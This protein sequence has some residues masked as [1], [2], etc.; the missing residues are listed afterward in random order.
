[1]R[2]LY[3]GKELALLKRWTGSG[4][5]CSDAHRLR[6]QEEY[7]QLALN[8]LLQAKPPRPEGP[9]P[10]EAKSGKPSAV[11]EPAD[12]V[13]VPSASAPSTPRIAAPVS[14]PASQKASEGT[15]TKPAYYE[16]SS[17][18]A[19]R[20]TMVAPATPLISA[21]IDEPEHEEPAP[22]EAAGFIV[23]MPIAAL[24]EVAEMSH[25]DL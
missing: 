7:N 18:A 2:C 13:A 3:C 24:A 1:M 19:V 10:N 23:E 4:E 9:Q 17:P 5:F 15:R 12:E 25:P 22:A 16:P 6:Y 11:A 21:R 8:R 14:E 20:E